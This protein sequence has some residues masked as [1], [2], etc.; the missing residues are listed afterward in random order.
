VIKGLQ[1]MRAAQSPYH[2]GSLK[3]ERFL[4]VVGKAVFAAVHL[5][6]S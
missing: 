4:H 5:H 2:V 6:I 3:T 1:G